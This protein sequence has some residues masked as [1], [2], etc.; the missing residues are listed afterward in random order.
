MP[1]GR[2][3]S[4]VVACTVVVVVVVVQVFV[5]GCACVCVC[6]SVCV[7]VFNVH[8]CH[9]FEW[10]CARKPPFLRTYARPRFRPLPSPLARSVTL[11]FLIFVSSPCYTARPCTG[12]TFRW[13]CK[14][15]SF[16]WDSIMPLLI[17]ITIPD[18]YELKKVVTITKWPVG[19][20]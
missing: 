19:F 10:T 18:T 6:D 15:W 5:C 1:I 20:T 2:P 11:P 13:H 17:I 3:C 8:S 14:K 12:C 16:F 7:C 9:P 4:W